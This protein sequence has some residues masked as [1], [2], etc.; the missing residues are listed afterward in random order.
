MWGVVEV[1]GEECACGGGRGGGREGEGCL[2]SFMSADVV[3][4]GGS[5]LEEGEVVVW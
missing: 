1:G 2:V 3:E 4:L 5:R